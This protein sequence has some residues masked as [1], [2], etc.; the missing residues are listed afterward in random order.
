MLRDYNKLNIV[1]SGAKVHQKP[2][3]LVNWEAAKFWTEG[4]RLDN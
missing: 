3:L 1:L 2:W 4:S